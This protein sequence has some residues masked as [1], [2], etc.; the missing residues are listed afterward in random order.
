MKINT[1][2][3]LAGMFCC[4]FLIIFL[5]FIHAAPTI[6]ANNPKYMQ[7][8]TNVNFRSL[9]STSSNVIRKLSQ[10]TKLKVVGSIDNFY[11]VQLSTNE[12]GVVYKDYTTT[13]STGP[14]NASTYTNIRKNKWSYKHKRCKF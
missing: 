13:S 14:S 7:T 11:I 10:G 4:S 5:S 6:Q 12:V 1:K 2:F 3:K 9:A 8:T